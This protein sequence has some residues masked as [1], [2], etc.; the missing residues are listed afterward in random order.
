[1]GNKLAVPAP[2]ELEGVTEIFPPVAPITTVIEFNPCG[3]FMFEP[4]GTVHV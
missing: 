4:G 1:M 3:E 2:Q